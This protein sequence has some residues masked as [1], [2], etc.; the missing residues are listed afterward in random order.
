M[1]PYLFVCFCETV[2]E[3]ERQQT[4]TEIAAETATE[5][6]TETET[7][8]DIIGRVMTSRNGF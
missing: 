8:A 6:A 1:F 5:I 7:A 2:K 3:R 4:E